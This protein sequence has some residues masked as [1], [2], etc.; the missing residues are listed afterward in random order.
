MDITING[1]DAGRLEIGLFGDVVPKTVA[2][3]KG[4]ITHDK[5]FIQSNYQYYY[6]IKEAYFLGNCNIII[7]CLDFRIYAFRISFTNLQK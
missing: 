5:V 7:L 4:L 3:F 1:E 2:N 6:I